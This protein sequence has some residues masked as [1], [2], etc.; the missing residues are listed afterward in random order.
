M[1]ISEAYRVFGLSPA[2]TIEAIKLR[3]KELVRRFHPDII[4]SEN[5][6]I[7]SVNI[8][9]DVILDSRDSI[10]A[11][12]I[13]ISSEL[14]R[15]LKGLKLAMKKYV[16]GLSTSKRKSKVR[17]EKLA[18]LAVILEYLKDGAEE[19][20]EY[21]TTMSFVNNIIRFESMPT[22]VKIS[23]LK[24]RKAYF[25]YID[26]MQQTVRIL[27]EAFMRLDGIKRRTSLWRYYLDKC[28]EDYDKLLATGSETFT[29]LTDFLVQFYDDIAHMVKIFSKHKSLLNY[30]DFY[31]LFTIDKMKKKGAL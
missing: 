21:Y 24:D 31:E 25:I 9:Y 16:D 5:D 4:G 15:I 22:K 23:S 1:D 2:D 26:I 11:E 8:A 3:Y 19:S 7:R 20:V 29:A 10:P 27:E 13:V 14:D 6:D 12:A 18:D 28:V 30:K 17:D